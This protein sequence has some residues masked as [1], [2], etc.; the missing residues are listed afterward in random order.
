MTFLCEYCNNIYNSKYLLSRHQNSES[1]KKI[2]N[3][4]INY[5]NKNNEKLKEI[6]KNLSR[7][8]LLNLTSLAL[9]IAI[10]LELSK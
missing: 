10:F 3:I 6:Q 8:Y 4:I 5:N 7:T 1:C 2:Q 9:N